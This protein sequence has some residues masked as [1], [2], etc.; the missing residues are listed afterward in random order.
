MMTEQG[1]DQHDPIDHCRQR[2]LKELLLDFFF[3]WSVNGNT[4]PEPPPEGYKDVV[5]N[6]IYIKLTFVD[7]LRL[8]FNGHLHV[9]AFDY[10]EN[11]VGYVSS[12]TY[13]D[14]R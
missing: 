12:K 14:T 11:E 8:L 7:R 9:G 6:H 1:S 2:P 13:A 4:V 3:P 5:I 10:T